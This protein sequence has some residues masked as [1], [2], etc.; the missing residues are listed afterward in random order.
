MLGVFRD[1][2][3]SSSVKTALDVLLDKDLIYRTQTGYIIY[4]Y[5]FQFPSPC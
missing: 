1:L 2:P 5:F 3:F 4:D